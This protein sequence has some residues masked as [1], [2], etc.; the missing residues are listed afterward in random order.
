ME[1]LLK[2][3]TLL[4]AKLHSPTLAVQVILP[5]V[6]SLIREALTE[7]LQKTKV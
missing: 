7:N 3:L 6:T 1:K 2:K 4:F 5:P